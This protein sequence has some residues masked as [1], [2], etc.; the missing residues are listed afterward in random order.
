MCQSQAKENQAEAAVDATFVG[1][2]SYVVERCTWSDEPRVSTDEFRANAASVL[3]GAVF[4]KRRVMIGI[5]EQRDP[6]R[7]IGSSITFFSPPAI[8]PIAVLLPIGEYEDLVK[9]RAELD[10]LREK[11]KALGAAG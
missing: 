4:R 8:T 7:G 9:H 5:A 1:T 3:E 6:G 10:R 2:R 11:L